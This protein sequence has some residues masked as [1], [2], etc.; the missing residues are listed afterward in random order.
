MGEVA[1]RILF[2]DSDPAVGR[3]FRRTLSPHHFE[4]DIAAS[5]EEA[6]TLAQRIVYPIVVT[7]MRM[8]DLD[9]SVLVEML[10]RRNPETTFVLLTSDREL[11][12]RSNGV[13]DGRIVSILSKPWDPEELIA[14]LG[15]ARDQRTLRHACERER[16]ALRL[17]DLACT[18]PV[19]GLANRSG[20]DRCISAALSRARRREQRV[21]VMYLDLDGFKEVNDGYGHAAGDGLLKLV[22]ERLSHVVRG[23]DAVA[24]LG[25]DEFALLIEELGADVDAMEFAER[26]IAALAEPMRVDE[27]SHKLTASMGVAL[28][29]DSGTSGE[30]LLQ[31]AD[32]AMYMAKR[33]GRNRS[34]MH[35]PISRKAESVPPTAH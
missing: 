3:T 28:Y 35:V 4:I 32:Q 5:A 31:A 13:V 9:S 2:V 18:D 12:A 33:R 23:Y 16:R 7:D 10:T 29:P 24:R 22:G 27:V 15:R 34:C 25:G 17:Q 1:S 20:L 30:Q 26:V 8:P 14:T 11:R 21:A 19:T 6:L